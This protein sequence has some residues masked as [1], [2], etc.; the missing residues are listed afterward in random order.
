MLA[1]LGLGFAL[2][3]NA[4]F[5]EESKQEAAPAVGSSASAGDSEVQSAEVAK[6]EGNVRRPARD[7][8]QCLVD[9]SAVDDLRRRRDQLDE[10][11]RSLVERERAFELKEKAIAE[12]VARLDS[13]R[14]AIEREKDLRKKESQEKVSKLVETFETMTP[15]TAAPILATLD[16]TLAVEVMRRLSTQKLAKILNFVEPA[17]SAR[18]T[19]RLVGASD[20]ESSLNRAGASNGASQSVA[21]DRQPSSE[22]GVGAA[23]ANPSAKGGE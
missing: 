16:E 22:G 8:D 14:S 21:A 20:G 9:E 7:S 3:A 4:P 13:V 10:R 2:D 18:L 6:K 15:K 12:Q 5:A 1:V 11:E 19:E 23:A 17:R